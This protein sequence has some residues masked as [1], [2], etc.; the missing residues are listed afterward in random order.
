L[1]AAA[2]EHYDRAYFDHWYRAEGFGSL[3]RLRRKVAFAVGAAEYLLDRPVRS[4]LDVGCGEGAWQPALAALRPRVRYLG[5]D[6]SRYAVE[7]YGRRRNLRAG[8][9]GELGQVVPVDEGPFDLIVCIDVL[10]YV[11][12]A[13]IAAGLRAV[14]ARLGGVALIE[15]FTS[16]DDYEGDLARYRRRSPARYGRWFADAG[17]GR[18]GPT[19]FAGSQRA[20]ALSSFESA[21]DR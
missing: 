14:A 8:A 12:A 6:P 21:V 7:R 16:V 9:F 18:I 1:S 20:P 2:A 19:L 3:A 13:Q 5:V 11:P 10:G 4:V 15:V 17:L